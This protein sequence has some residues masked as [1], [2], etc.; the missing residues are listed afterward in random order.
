MLGGVGCDLCAVARMERAAGRPGFCERVF[1]PLEREYCEGRGR[2]KFASLAARFAAKEA[3]LKALG[4]G[5]RYGSL[6]EIE[7]GQ[8]ELGKPELRLYGKFAEVAAAKGVV[9]MAVSL[10][11][12]REYAGAVVV[13]EVE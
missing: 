12:E 8:D 2:Q 4:T 10:T 5:L 9:R 6:Q 11:H 1:T 7:V 3:V 13:L